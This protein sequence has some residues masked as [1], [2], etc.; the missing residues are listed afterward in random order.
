MSEGKT[1][2]RKPF[3]LS[4]NQAI[5]KELKHLAV[6]ED[7]NLNDLLEEAMQDLLKKY[8]RKGVSPK[9]K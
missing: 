6:D 8:K 2:T 4:L 5:M 3:G 7:R 1:P 9:G